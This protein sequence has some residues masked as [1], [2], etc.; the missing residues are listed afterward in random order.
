[1]VPSVYFNVVPVKLFL[2]LN[3]LLN[4]SDFSERSVIKLFEQLRDLNIYNVIIS[5]NKEIIFNDSQ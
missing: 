1:M 2:L 5:K 3:Y 4:L